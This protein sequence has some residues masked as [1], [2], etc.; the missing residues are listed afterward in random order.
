MALP[1]HF[2]DIKCSIA[3]SYLDFEAQATKAWHGIIQELDKVT[4]VIKEEGII[5][6]C[7]CLHYLL[8]NDNLSYIFSQIVHSPNQLSLA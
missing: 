7:W 3:S 4:N 6:G 1:S 8:R 5:V 2:I